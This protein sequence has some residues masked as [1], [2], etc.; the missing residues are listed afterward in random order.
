M[1]PDEEGA[2][3]E[4]EKWTIWANGLSARKKG[5]VGVIIITLDRDML[6][7]GVQLQFFAT[8]NKAEY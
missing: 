5:I 3:D 7:Y 1:I 4:V 6:R 2:L 8:N